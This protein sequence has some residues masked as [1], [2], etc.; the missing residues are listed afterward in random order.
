MKIADDIIRIEKIAEQAKVILKKKKKDQE[1]KNIEQYLSLVR[2]RDVSVLV[3]GE[4]KRG[5]SSFI[6]AFLGEHICPVDVG[7]ATSAVSVIKYGEKMK[8]TRQ[9]G[10]LDDLKSEELSS[11]EDVE[12][13]A[14][15]SAEMIDNTVLLIIEIP[16][17][18]LKDGLVLFDTPG[19][20]GLDPRHAFL[21]TYF[22]PKADITLFVTDAGEP[23]TGAEITFFKKK[24]LPYAKQ[25]A[26]LVNKSDRFSSEQKTKEWVTDVQMK[27][28][29]QKS[30]IKVIPVSSKLKQDFLDTND[31]MSLTESNFLS[32][33]KE[34]DDLVDSFRRVIMTEL[35]DYVISV[36]TNVL[37]PIKIQ[38]DQI[39]VPDPQLI[40]KLEKE[41]LGFKEQKERLSNPNSAYRMKIASIIKQ[42]KNNV[43][44]RLSE[45][46]VILSTT[47]LRELVSSPSAK[48]DPNWLLRQLNDG[49]SSISAELDLIIDAAIEKV[50]QSIGYDIK[51]TSSEGFNFTIDADL[52]PAEKSL[53]T[54]ACNAV[55][56]TLPGMGVFMLTASLAS[57]VFT[58]GS[59]LPLVIGAASALGFIGK[60]AADASKQADATFFQNQLAPQISIAMS[61]LRAYIN[62]RFEDFNTSLIAALQRGT[63]E[64]IQQM[65]TSITDLNKLKAETAQQKQLKGK[66]LEEELKPVEQVLGVAKLFM[67]NPFASKEPS[68]ASTTTTSSATTKSDDKTEFAKNDDKTYVG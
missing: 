10:N 59:T 48:K 29:D 1:I 34:I 35:R 53:G 33:E 2:K 37:T 25:K 42:A 12:R 6:N 20:G 52:T 47:K 4:F 15:G 16:N 60:N 57:L 19:V 49:V 21:T 50:M 30:L 36:L 11:Y 58:G 56:H 26:V 7:I 44:I 17:E 8:V 63:Q 24:I 54:V 43:E 28:G 65:E 46:S 27:L 31:E 13:Y 55:R 38:I 14:K 9:Y 68:S 51:S 41:L 40:T 39:K 62:N 64:L 67:T 18:K 61:H 22:L 32:V 45:E 5:K 23:I 3:C 66:L